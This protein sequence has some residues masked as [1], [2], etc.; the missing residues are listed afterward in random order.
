MLVLRLASISYTLSKKRNI[1]K[2]QEKKINFQ[3]KYWKFYFWV[4]NQIT[5]FLIFFQN[6]GETTRASIKMHR[7]HVGDGVHLV[8]HAL[9]PGDDDVL[10]RSREGGQQLPVVQHVHDDAVPEA[11]AAARDGLPPGDRPTLPGSAQLTLKYPPPPPPPAWPGWVGQ[12]H[13]SMLSAMGLGGRPILNA[14]KTGSM[15]SL[16]AW[17][18]NR[19]GG[20]DPNSSGADQLRGPMSWWDNPQ[21]RPLLWVRCGTS[22]GVVLFWGLF[23]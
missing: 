11:E 23:P 4:Q 6:W 16:T 22:R 5:S 19:G 18:S 7:R 3:K 1:K 12:F 21:M 13:G 2:R 9:V 14:L 15:L 20:G 10:D 8:P 17:G